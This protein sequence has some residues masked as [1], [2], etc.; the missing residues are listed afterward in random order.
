MHL[1]CAEKGRWWGAA[2]DVIAIA[3]APDI[4]Y[5]LHST[6]W[7]VHF[8]GRRQRAHWYELYVVLLMLSVS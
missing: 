8:S 5:G 2:L 7:H 1:I 4:A 3:D 6:P